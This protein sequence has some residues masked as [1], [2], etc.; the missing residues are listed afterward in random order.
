VALVVNIAVVKFPL[1]VA[2]G[3]PVALGNGAFLV[4]LFH[5][6]LWA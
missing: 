6:V 3:I 4:S 1:R 2:M 5:I